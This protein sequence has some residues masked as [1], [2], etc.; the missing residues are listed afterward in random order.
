MTKKVAG[1]KHK[2]VAQE[3]TKPVIFVDSRKSSRLVEPVL[4]P[5]ISFDSR[6]IPGHEGRKV[7]YKRV[8]GE[9]EK[10][11]HMYVFTDG[12]G[13]LVGRSGWP[14]VRYC[15]KQ[16]DNRDRLIAVYC[17]DKLGRLEKYMHRELKANG[18]H[19][20]NSWYNIDFAF[21][22]LVA[23]FVQEKHAAGGYPD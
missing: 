7:R 18:Y 20:H 6:E 1:I 17:W 3:L 2:T 15:E 21:L 10:G 14:D 4:R 5:T 23:T 19:E 11:E 22:K 12:T 13:C 16:S 9:A 8:P